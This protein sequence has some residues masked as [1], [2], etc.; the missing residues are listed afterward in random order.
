[1]Y[2]ELDTNNC[3][4]NFKRPDENNRAVIPA[5]FYLQVLNKDHDYI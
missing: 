1:M 3:H 5:T 4:L 2:L